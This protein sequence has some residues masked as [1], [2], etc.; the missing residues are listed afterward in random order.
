MP[1]VVGRMR[2]LMALQA[3]GMSCTHFCVVMAIAHA[4]GIPRDD[5][6]EDCRHS[7][8]SRFTRLHWEVLLSPRVSSGGEASV[9]GLSERGMIGCS[10]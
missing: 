6:T 10:Q 5:L 8:D 2:S 7:L 3:P 9:E 4:Q 1:Q